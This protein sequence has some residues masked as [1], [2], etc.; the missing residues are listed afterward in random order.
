MLPTATP[1]G[2]TSQ[3]SKGTEKEI[4]LAEYTGV[5]GSDGAAFSPDKAQ[6]FWS[7]LISQ[8][9]HLVPQS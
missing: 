8:Q 7:F 1:T 5:S 4:K 3:I 9:P 6:Q 2:F